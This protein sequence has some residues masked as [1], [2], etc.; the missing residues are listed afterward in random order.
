MEF[1]LGLLPSFV[2]IKSLSV[3]KTEI[4]LHDFMF[5]DSLPNYTAFRV[6]Q[7]LINLY[8][9]RFG[10]CRIKTFS[11][12]TIRLL[13]I[14]KDW[15]RAR[16]RGPHHTDQSENITSSA[17]SESIIDIHQITAHFLSRPVLIMNYMNLRHTFRLVVNY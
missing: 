7:T 3:G 8:I 11:H 14:V 6:P 12:F 4:T 15:D 1:W 9:T 17:R 5:G 2:S 10:L 13:H 16:R